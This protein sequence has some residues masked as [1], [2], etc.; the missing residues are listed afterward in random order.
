VLFIDLEVL[1]DA[2]A[3]LVGVIHKTIIHARVMGV[4]NKLI[5]AFETI[6]VVCGFEKGSEYIRRA[7]TILQ[8]HDER[9]VPKVCSQD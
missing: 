8:T 3:T 5:H 9:Q 6:Y 7:T 4:N 2:N 1:Q